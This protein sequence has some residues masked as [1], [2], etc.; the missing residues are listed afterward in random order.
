[1]MRLRVQGDPVLKQPCESI[2]E[3][4]ESTVEL[5]ATLIK[6]MRKYGG[7]GLAA[8]QLG[9]SVR[10]FCATIGGEDKVFINP[11]VTSA[12][13]M[14]RSREGC[15][16]LPGIVDELYRYKNITISYKDEHGILHEGTYEDRDAIVIQH[17][18]H[19]LLGVLF[20]DLL[21]ELKQNIIKRKMAKLPKKYAK[22]YQREVLKSKSPPK[23]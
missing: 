16:S 4:G 14:V 5:K 12:T 18:M 23:R 6:H 8:N 20:C 15:L 21:S 22:V 13:G 19:H 1:M 11:I 2:T 10:A 3:F 9:M 17:E 7:V